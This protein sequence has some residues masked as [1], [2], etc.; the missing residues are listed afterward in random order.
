MFYGLPKIQKSQLI[1]N[2][3]TDIDDEYLELLEPEDLTFRTIVA[4]PACE[5]HRLSNLIVILLKPFI[6]CET[7]RLSN[8]IVIL[9]K[10][11]IEKVNRYVRDDID[12]LKHVPE[13]VPQNTL[14][15]TYDVVSLYT[16]ISHD[17]GLEAI[18]KCL[19]N[20][21]ELIHKRFSKEFI[22]ESIKVILENNNFYFNDIMFNQVRGTTI[23]TKVIVKQ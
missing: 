6:E 10:P 18:D 22:L 9:L 8:L 3:C 16:N 4:G 17:L 20:Y 21:P 19:T 13:I 2:K 12:F 23:G 1:N 11:F 7:H 5:T 15:V 14:P